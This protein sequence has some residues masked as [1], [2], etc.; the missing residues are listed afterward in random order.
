MSLKPSDMWQLI[1]I[2]EESIIN[3]RSF[4]YRDENQR[5]SVIFRRRPTNLH[6]KRTST[7]ITKGVQNDL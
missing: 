1:G 4:H 2:N 6:L 5:D 7:Q 3:V